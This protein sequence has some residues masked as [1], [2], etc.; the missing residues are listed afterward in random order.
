MRLSPP[1]IAVALVLSTVS[2]VGLGR[3]PA[4]EVDPRSKEWVEA[5]VTAMSAGDL[6]RANDFLETALAIDPGN[7]TAYVLMGEVA[8][9]QKLDGKAIRMFNIALEMDDKDVRALAGLGEAYVGKG[10]IERAKANL[11]KIELLC[12]SNCKAGD[13][14]ASVI[15]RAGMTPVRSAS[16][17]QSEPTIQAETP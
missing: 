6:E 5:G 9:A 11:A 17:V 12:K 15:D 8:H 13:R 4:Q 16:A 14:L 2:S 1:A 7:R 3:G 10:A